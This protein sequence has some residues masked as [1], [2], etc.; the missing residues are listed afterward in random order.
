M[1]KGVYRPSRIKNGKRVRSKFYRLVYRVDSMPAKAWKALRTTDQ[2]VAQKKAAEFLRD[3]ERELH[4]LIPPQ[5][6]R[7]AAARPILVQL[8]EFVSDL[9]AQGRASMYV[10]NVERRVRRILADC[11]WARANQISPDGFQRWRSAHTDK[12]PKT[13]NDYQDA[14]AGFLKWLVRNNREERNVLDGVPKAQTRGKERRR[15]RAFSVQELNRLVSVSGDRKLGYLLAALTGLRRAELEQLQWGDV[16]LEAESPFIAVRDSTS[17]NAMR[18]EIPLHPQVTK[19]LREARPEGVAEMQTV[20]CRHHLASMWMLKKDLRSAGIP[21]LDGQGRRAD[22]HALR[23]TFNMLMALRNT[24]LQ[25]RKLAM[26]HSDIKLTANTYV[27]GALLPLTGAIHALPWLGESAPDC[28]PATDTS[29]PISSPSVT[30][31]LTERASERLVSVVDEHEVA[32][33][34][35]T[36]H[37][38]G[39]GCLARIRT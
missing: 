7:D 21:F 35:T 22:F 31:V 37:N 39:N 25:T 34:G 3:K 15:R 30:K 29:C 10:Y 18:A 32:P 2:Q 19:G 27:D 16:H 33:N 4:G 6:V 23:G 17:K 36:G 13:L 28:A 8:I 14:L 20:L 12:A 5:S 1:I 9:S 24:D 26:R 38:T 11:G